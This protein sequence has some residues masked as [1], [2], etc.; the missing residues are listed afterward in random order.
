MCTCRLLF[1]TREK[2]EATCYSGKSIAWQARTHTHTHAHACVHARSTSH[3]CLLCC[4]SLPSC[5]S[6]YIWK[7][8]HGFYTVNLFDWSLVSVL[9]S[10]FCSLSVLSVKCSCDGLVCLPANV[11]THR[12][13]S[14]SIRLFALYIFKPTQINHLTLCMLYSYFFFKCRQQNTQVASQLQWNRLIVNLIQC[15]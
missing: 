2:S 8:S 15:C 7:A 14:H 3:N 13:E 6:I 11:S 10:G 5:W 12:A 4:K 1:L 9:P